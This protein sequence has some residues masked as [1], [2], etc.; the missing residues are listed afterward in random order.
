MTAR[1]FFRAPLEGKVSPSRVFW[2]Y[3]VLA[4]LVI[5]ALGV[6]LPPDPRVGRLFVMAELFWTLY[7]I[8]AQYRSAVLCR[9]PAR[10]RW[11]RIGC[12]IS[13]FLLPFV[14]YI[15]LS[16]ALDSEMSQLDGLGL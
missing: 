13:F 2:I 4:S 7:V 16:G 3:G 9:T 15:E 6:L 1:E 12:V 11:L 14:A 5:S 10:A 8:V